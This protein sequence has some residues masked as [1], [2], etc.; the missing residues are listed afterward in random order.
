[1]KFRVEYTTRATKDIK[2]FPINVQKKILKE[3]IHLETDPFPHKKKIKRIKGLK[4]PCFRL[5]IDFEYGTFRL[6][7]GI[8]KNIVFVLRI[9]SRKD[10]DKIIK[11]I[12]KS[13]FP[14]DI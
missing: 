12:K 10:A 1:M 9:I 11:S 8:E 4:F 13:E 2:G 7:Y 14:P 3:S 5:R 6:F